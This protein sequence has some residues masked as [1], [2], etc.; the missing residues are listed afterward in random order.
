M[1]QSACAVSRSRSASV[2]FIFVTLL[3]DTLGIG[4]MAPV[5]PRVVAS[6]MGGNFSASSGYYGFF[7]SVYAAMQFVFAPILGGLSDRYGRRVVILSSLAGAA[8][9]YLLLAF[10][11][12]LPWLFLG[13][14][15]SGITGASFSTATAYIAD[16]TPPD[17]RA[18]SFGLMGAA[19]GLGFIIGPALGG[20]LGDMNM[21]MPFLVSAA[22]NLLNFLYGLFVLPESLRAE[23]RRPFSLARA[24]P[25]SS[26][27]NLGRQSIVLGLTGV[28]VCTYM[29]QQMLQTMWTMYMPYRFAWSAKETGLS[30]A[31]VGATSIIVQGGLIRAVIPR[32]GERRALLFGSAMATIGQLGFGLANRGWMIYAV[33]VVSS[34]GGLGGPAA[35]AIISRNVPA[36][37]QG[38]VQGSLSSLQ[39]VAAIIGPLI[40]TQLFEHFTAGGDVPYVPGISFFAAT[41][42]QGMSLLLAIRLF[43]RFPAQAEAPPAS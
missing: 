7:A 17:R 22:L 1:L 4:V 35:Q 13:R 36:S 21:R 39:S 28:L 30:L 40:A 12:S 41:V 29:A 14:I 15:I 27:K 42:F 43:A 25:F 19:F 6:F 33:L 2:A 38:E 18:Q 37:E 34:L 3:L 11:P 20:V 8:V 23:H 24:N 16:I 5:F 26:F 31:M 10:A 9:D 32:I